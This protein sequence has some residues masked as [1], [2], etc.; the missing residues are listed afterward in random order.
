[1]GEKPLMFHRHD[2]LWLDPE[3]RKAALRNIAFCVPP[4]ADRERAAALI[5]D[6]RIPA[7]TA[8]QQDVPPGFLRIGFSS[9]DRIGGTRFRVSAC[10]P[11]T[12]I[13]RRVDPF[14]AARLALREGPL[15]LRPALSA[16]TG[17]GKRSHLETGV[18]GSLALEAV[19]GLPYTRDGSDMDIYLRLREGGGEGLASFYQELL[20]CEVRFARRIDAELE[21]RE[22]AAINLK[23][24]F[25]PGQTLLAKTVRGPLILE[26]AELPA[27]LR[28]ASGRTAEETAAFADETAAM[29]TR[30]LLYEAACAPKPGLVTRLGSGNHRD[31]DFFTFIDSGLALGPFFRDCCRA[32]ADCPGA[33]ESLFPRLRERGR[34]AEA[35][36]FCATGGVNTHKGIIFSGGVICGAAGF[37]YGRGRAFDA[38]DL[39]DTAGKI[40]A[41]ALAD[42]RTD[43]SP[44][45]ATGGERA[46]VNHGLTGVRGEAA[47][48]FP[49]L[50]DSYPRLRDLR[51]QGYSLNDAGAAVLLSLMARTGDTNV[52][53][54]GGIQALWDIQRELAAFL[55]GGAAP[56]MDA[57]LAYAGELDRRMRESGVSPGG[58][59]D[60]L[61][62]SYFLLFLY[63]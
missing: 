3:G 15:R 23:E 22:G 57:M 62:L 18:F 51:C 36:M 26:K 17:A 4:D 19:T 38:E 9:P 40:A 32:G 16:L 46:F 13:V 49:G 58:S 52:A 56:S 27:L 10:A 35:A 42:L 21:Y 20:A 2:L 43:G 28:R 50:R 25:S 59:A 48:G 63:L 8:S 5:G 47:A 55:Y 12:S 33:P 14:Q 34:E 24:F 41:P 45:A 61:A 54:R 1:L 11:L 29:M 44:A 53:A 60:L 7:I 31:M 6:P 30:A 37:L 39:L